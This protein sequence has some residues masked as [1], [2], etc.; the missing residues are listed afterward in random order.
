MNKKS[1]TINFEKEIGKNVFEYD[2]KKYTYQVANLELIKNNKIEYLKEFAISF[3][4]N[5]KTDVRYAA[6]YFNGSMFGDQASK[7]AFFAS[8]YFVLKSEPFFVKGKKFYKNKI[9]A[10][11]KTL[12]L[13]SIVFL[14]GW[15]SNASLPILTK[16]SKSII[17]NNPDSSFVDVTNYDEIKTRAKIAK[18]K[19]KNLAKVARKTAGKERINAVNTAMINNSVT[20][21]VD[22]P[23]R[24]YNGQYAVFF[25]NTKKHGI[26]KFASYKAGIMYL[27]K[28][29]DDHNAKGINKI[30]KIACL[31]QICLESGLSP[32][33]AGFISNIG[34]YASNVLGIKAYGKTPRLLSKDDDYIN[35]KLIHS[36]FEIFQDIPSCIERY[37]E[38]TNRPRYKNSHKY[39]NYMTVLHSLAK[40]GYC[41]NENYAKMCSTKV[42]QFLKYI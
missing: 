19:T 25:G 36:G 4:P 41:S 3:L 40:N 42:A 28:I 20:F 9:L 26:H 29:I 2:V 31:S 37:A 39:N 38:I 22:N 16:E 11:G 33:T 34:T 6:D 10:N 24:M 14:A 32:N 15:H 1:I 7:L 8:N 18:K 35:G 5:L 30:N 12:I 21:S 27:N 23:K 13:I 17:S